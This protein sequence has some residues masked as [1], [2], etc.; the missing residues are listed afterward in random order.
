MTRRDD[1]SVMP[2]SGKVFIEAHVIKGTD[3]I[4]NCLSS[5]G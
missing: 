4:T 5:G 1:K 3:D 2:G